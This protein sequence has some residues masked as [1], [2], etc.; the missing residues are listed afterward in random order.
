LRLGLRL[1]RRPLRP[2]GL[3]EEDGAGAGGGGVTMVVGVGAGA[4]SSSE[5]VARIVMDEL[6]D[7]PDENRADM[8][9]MVAK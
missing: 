6:P 9:P 5:G 4:T 3:V 2:V 1:W 8:L 7:S